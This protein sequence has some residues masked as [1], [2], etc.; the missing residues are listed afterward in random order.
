MSIDERRLAGRERGRA[1]VQ[2][3]TVRERPGWRQR[4][5]TYIVNHGIQVMCGSGGDVTAAAATDVP[6]MSGA[7]RL[8]WL[9]A[10]NAVGVTRFVATSGLGYDFVCHTGDLA[11]FPFYYR[12]AYQAELELCAAWLQGEDPPVVYDIGANGGFFSTHLAQMLAGRTPRIYAF[13]PVPATFAKLAHAVQRL[14]LNASVLPVPVAVVGSPGPVRISYSERN[15]LLA[16]ISPRGLNPQA[17]D[18]LAQAEGITLDEFCASAGAFPQLV[19]IDVEGGE[20]GVLRGAQR[21]LSRS[22][23]PAVLFEFNPVAL[24]ESGSSARALF[25]LL[26]GYTLHYVDDLGGQKIPFGDPVDPQEIDW[27]CN[28]FAVPLTQSAA[29]RWA[30]VSERLGRRA[31]MG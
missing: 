8:A 7:A 6:L 22:D 24:T 3:N 31:D 2:V 4:L 20:T 1:T 28:L 23:R 17:G 9:K 10:L 21:L 12:R 16:R 27:I 26:A 11:N 13:E 18:K 19:K 5:R 25:D 29:M 30:S 14:G 15:S